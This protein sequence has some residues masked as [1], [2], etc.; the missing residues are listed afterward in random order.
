MFQRYEEI[1]LKES[2]HTLEKNEGG[3]L[4]ADRIQGHIDSIYTLLHDQAYAD[5]EHFLFDEDLSD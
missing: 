3:E 1:I 5:L 2:I 4:T